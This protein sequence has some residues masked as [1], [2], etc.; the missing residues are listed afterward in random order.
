M[1]S[2]EITSLTLDDAV[3]SL[4]SFH[5]IVGETNSITDVSL[6]GLT[7]SDEN[8]SDL[9]ALLGIGPLDNVTVDQA[10]FDSYADEFN[11]FAEEAGNTLTVI[12]YGDSNRDG[13]F[14]SSDFVHVFVAGKYE[15]GE[16]ARWS[17]GDWNGDRLFDSLDFVVAFE[18]GGYEQG[19]QADVAAVPEPATM[20]LLLTAACLLLLRRSRRSLLLPALVAADDAWHVS[21]RRHLPLGYG[22]VDSRDR[23]N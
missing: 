18:N 20:A 15:T 17:E 9:A 5:A 21:P 11:S 16:D 12:G 14:N 13:Q 23:R 10:L 22:R 3:L 6:V 19:L 7:F 1:D 2:D 4:G 8:P